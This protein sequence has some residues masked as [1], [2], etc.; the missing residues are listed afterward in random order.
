M[1]TVAGLRASRGAEGRLALALTFEKK[2]HLI[3]PET[4]RAAEEARDDG[5]FC[6]FGAAPRRARLFFGAASGGVAR[7]VLDFAR[8]EGS[9]VLLFLRA[10]DEPVGSV[11][12]RLYYFFVENAEACGL[13]YLP[14]LAEGEALPEAFCGLPPGSVVS[15]AGGRALPVTVP[16]AAVW[17]EDAFAAASGGEGGLSP[18]GAAGAGPA[19]PACEDGS[20]PA[21]PAGEEPFLRLL[22]GVYARKGRFGLLAQ[23]RMTIS[24]VNPGTN[25]GET[26][27]F[28]HGVRGPFAGGANGNGSAAAAPRAPAPAD[29]G[30]SDGGTAAPRKA[31]DKPGPLGKP[32]PVYKNGELL[33]DCGDRTETALFLACVSDVSE[34][35]GIVRVAGRIGNGTLPAESV[36]ALCHG[37]TYTAET[38]NGEF[39][40]RMPFG[41]GG[42]VSLYGTIPGV[43][44]LPVV[45]TFGVECRLRNRKDSFALGDVSVIRKAGANKLAVSALTDGL[46]SE[47]TACPKDGRNKELLD[48]WAKSRKIF[49]KRRIWLFDGGDEETEL[50]CRFCKQV[51]DGIDKYLVPGDIEFG[52]A[53][54]LLH[55]LFAE[56]IV[57]ENPFGAD[58]KLRGL[59]NA[60]FVKFENEIDD[61]GEAYALCCR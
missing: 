2:R 7:E 20:S 1:R 61:Y 19:G 25:P 28:S 3:A 29:S 18:A 51:D 45:M 17:A 52:S 15:G 58:E 31:E 48:R 47:L 12:R 33:L 9:E 11:L 59:C 36:T 46:V 22:R 55:A 40:V 38:A 14:R 37:E 35:N 44:T 34:R 5:D 56:R 26:A 10:G 23:A 53:D 50:F 32:V 4:L 49:G 39:D 8:E 16:G 57:G 60:R 30:T 42:V 21:G 6:F 27:E 43:G 13:A 54:H 41:S 24:A